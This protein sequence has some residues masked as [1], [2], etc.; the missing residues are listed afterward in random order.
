MENYV[1][2]W[3][4]RLLRVGDMNQSQG[5]RTCGTRKDFLGARHSLLSH[6]LFLISFARPAFQHCEEHVY[7]PTYLTVYR[8]YMNYR[9]YQII[10]YCEWNIFTQIGSSAKCCVDIYH[11]GAGLSVAGRIRDIGQNVLQYSFETGSSSSPVTAI[12][13]SLSHSSRRSLLEIYNN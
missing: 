1:F 3:Y 7:A 9:C 2:K 13:C 5:C 6:F 4:G 12:F 10:C 11:G 8:L